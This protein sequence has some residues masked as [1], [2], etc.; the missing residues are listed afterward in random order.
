[1]AIRYAAKRG[2]RVAAQ[3]TGHGAVTLG[4]LADTLLIRTDRMRGVQM[5]PW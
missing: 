5:D 3:G 2:L 4:P 1:M